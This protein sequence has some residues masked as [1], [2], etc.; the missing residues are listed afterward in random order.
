MPES[1]NIL[2][3]NVKLLSKTIEKN[4]RI[5]IKKMKKKMEYKHKL[6][7][8][9]NTTTTKLRKIKKILVFYLNLKMF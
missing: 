4:Y 1:S 7:M 2:N 6:I 9:E 5:D 3:D 8:Y